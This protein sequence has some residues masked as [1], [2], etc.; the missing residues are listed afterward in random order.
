MPGRQPPSQAA[1]ALTARP[2]AAAPPAPPQP[3]VHALDLGNS[4]RDGRLFIPRATG[5]VPSPLIVLLH[6]AGGDASSML[7]MLGSAAEEY[8]CLLLAPDARKHT[9]DFL[10]DDFGPDVSFLDR[11]LRQTFERCSIDPTR[12]A[13]AGFSDGASYALTLG[14][15]NGDLFTHILAFSPGFMRPPR[16]EGSPR[17]YVSHGTDDRVLPIA[18]CSRSLV[19]QLEH[20]RYDVLY[21]EFQGPHIVPEPIIA[22]AMQWFLA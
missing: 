3:G 5:K 11:A 13:I 17:V 15:A 4:V 6:G 2:V 1:A 14:L 10:I 21:R 19:P 18:R 16:L 7:R 22:E 20:W 8:H 12:V 9:W